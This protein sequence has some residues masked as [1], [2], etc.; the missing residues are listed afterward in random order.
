[1]DSDLESLIEEIP[2]VTHNICFHGKKLKKTIRNLSKY[3][4]TLSS[5]QIFITTCIM[6]THG[7]NSNGYPQ[8]MFSEKN[9]PGPMLIQLTLAIKNDDKIYHQ[10]ETGKTK[11]VE[12]SKNRF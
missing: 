1:M 6:D 2:K 4:Y 5:L 9:I 12:T 8:Y 10:N 3:T 11:V 7:G